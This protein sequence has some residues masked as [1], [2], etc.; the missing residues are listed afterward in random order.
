MKLEQFVEFQEYNSPND[1]SCT[2]CKEKNPWKLLGK[3]SYI[4]KPQ[5]GTIQTNKVYRIV[6]NSNKFPNVNK[7]NISIIGCPYGDWNN[8]H[9]TEGY[10]Y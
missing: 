4:Q 3:W 6:Y 10:Y 2:S 9:Y 1:I 5:I 7:I 8:K